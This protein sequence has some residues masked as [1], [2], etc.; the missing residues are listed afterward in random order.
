M[1]TST[2]ARLLVYICVIVSKS[3]HTQT[4]G[5]FDPLLNDTF[6]SIEL[7]G[8]DFEVSSF[9]QVTNDIPEQRNVLERFYQAT[10]GQHWSPI[11][12]NSA[13]LNA[14]NALEAGAPTTG[15]WPLADLDRISTYT[16]FPEP[17]MLTAGVLYINTSQFMGIYGLQVPWFTPGW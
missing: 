9:Y 14:Y 3:A 11:F 13:G 2:P 7:R 8:G 4:V 12:N 17:Q 1:I 10:G 16:Q 15:R 5:F 6:A